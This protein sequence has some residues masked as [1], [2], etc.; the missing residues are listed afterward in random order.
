MVGSARARTLAAIRVV[1]R[2]DALHEGAVGAGLVPTGSRDDVDIGLA[3]RLVEGDA[4]G[5]GR[6]QQG[7]E[8]DKHRQGAVS[9]VGGCRETSRR[10]P[11]SRE[12]SAREG[13]DARAAEGEAE[14]AGD[15]LCELRVRGPCTAR[16]RCVGRGEPAR[17]EAGER[18]RR[19]ASSRGRAEQCAPLKTLIVSLLGI[20]ACAPGARRRSSG[21]SASLRLG[22]TRAREALPPPRGSPASTSSA[23]SDAFLGGYGRSLHDQTAFHD[24]D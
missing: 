5:G 1:E 2:A 18:V 21:C 20:S 8:Q 24:S 12:L 19:D 7:R 9:R 23:Q 10:V 16:A 22:R 11:S 15:E 3:H 13:D 17:G 4:G 14:A 6:L